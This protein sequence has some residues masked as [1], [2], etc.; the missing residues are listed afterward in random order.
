MVFYNVFLLKN[1]S[2]PQDNYFIKLKQLYISLQLLPKLIHNK[3]WD[4]LKTSK[5]FNIILPFTN[6]KI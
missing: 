5:P 2:G 1:I 6:Y 3:L 4:C